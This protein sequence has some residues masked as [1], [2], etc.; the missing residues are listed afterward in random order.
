VPHWMASSYEGMMSSNMMLWVFTVQHL[1]RA[2]RRMLLDAGGTGHT[3]GTYI[4][5]FQTTKAAHR[6]H[7]AHI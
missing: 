7:T 1:A 2:T 3:F 5:C 6:H 4:H